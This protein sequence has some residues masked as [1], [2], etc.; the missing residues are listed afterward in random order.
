MSLKQNIREYNRKKTFQ[1]TGMI[2]RTCIGKL[3]A[4]VKDFWELGNVPYGSLMRPFK[5]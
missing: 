3:Q 2:K 5:W 4:L 1:Y